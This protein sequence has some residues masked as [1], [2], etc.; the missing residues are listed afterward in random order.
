MTVS[1]APGETVPH[2]G[3]YAVL[4][5]KPHD[6]YHEAFVRG[7]TFPNCNICSTL[8]RFRLIRPVPPIEK[9]DDFKSGLQAA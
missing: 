9:C 2:P 4:H 1:Y 8:V 5:G 3:V 7:G 6:H